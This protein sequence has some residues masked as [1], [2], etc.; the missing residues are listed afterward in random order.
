MP[1][2]RQRR[3]QFQRTVVRRTATNLADDS[4]TPSSQNGT[5][6]PST[7]VSTPSAASTPTPAPRPPPPPPQPKEKLRHSWVF[8]HMPDEDMQTKYYNEVTKLEEWRCRYYTKTY[9][10]SGST[11]GPGNH[12][13]D[14]HEIP[15]DSPRD[16][17]VKNI[18]R[19]LKSAFATAAAN[20]QKRRRLDTDEV[21]QD[22]LE[23]LWVRCLVS[24]NLAFNIVS[25]PEF[26]AFIL[27]LNSQAEEFLAK[28]ASSVKR[29]V[30]RQYHSLKAS[31]VILV[32]HKAR[33]KI[34]ISYDL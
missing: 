34:H 23:S 4:D 6:A 32:L 33:T 27:Y 9:L 28:G 18:Q 29:W 13:E 19:S 1:P 20:P 2:Q 31:T 12:L 8:R 15:R 10:T 25:N 16:T 30:I 11:S 7:A 3:L 14:F 26:R 17:V 5:P 21:S 22:K 24:C